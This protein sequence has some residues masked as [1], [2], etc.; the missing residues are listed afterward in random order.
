[1]TLSAHRRIQLRDGVACPAC[2]T[3]MPAHRTVADTDGRR[4]RECPRCGRVEVVPR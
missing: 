3:M 1:M 4:R 2:G